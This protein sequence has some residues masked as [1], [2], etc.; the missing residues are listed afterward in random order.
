MNKKY[1]VI[2]S[3]TAD[4]D[5]SRIIDYIAEDSI[6]NAINIFDKIKNKLYKINL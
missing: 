6:H 3:N 4:E 5:L 1:E 2:W